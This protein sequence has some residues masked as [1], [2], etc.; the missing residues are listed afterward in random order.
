[1][2][3]KLLFAII[4]VV[5]VGGVGYLFL[6]RN[7][8]PAP[9]LP[10][11]RDVATPSPEALAALVPDA[12]VF[13]E[14]QGVFF[15]SD[16]DG[17]KEYG[18]IA[19][20]PYSE[21]SADADVEVVVARWDAGAR[22]WRLAFRGWVAI[23]FVSGEGVFLEATDLNR[24]EKEELFSGATASGTGVFMSWSLVAMINGELKIAER[25]PYTL[26]TD[27]NLLCCSSA[28]VTDG[29]IVEV[30]PN[31]LPGQDKTEEHKG[32]TG[33]LFFRFD[34]TRLILERQEVIQ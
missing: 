3:Q 5:I 12:K 4:V 30:F 7:T 16:G 2:N 1:M 28:G 21:D 24:D 32:G 33:Q 9:V 15:D 18:F 31:F 6:S 22:Q 13:A 25:T 20:R 11:S 29:F 17:V 34:G 26:R 23:G 10:V 14:A 27:I 8:S 19:I